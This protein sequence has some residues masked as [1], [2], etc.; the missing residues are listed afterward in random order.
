MSNGKKSK[1]ASARMAV[2]YLPILAMVLPVHNKLAEPP[3][4][5]A[6]V[7]V[8]E[9][10]KYGQPQF[11]VKENPATELQRA[12]QAFNFEKDEDT[13]VITLKSIIEVYRDEPDV[14][15]LS[16]VNPRISLE[17]QSGGKKIIKPLTIMQSPMINAVNILQHFHVQTEMAWD[18]I[19][20]LITSLREPTNLASFTITVESELWWDELIPP[21]T[22]TILILTSTI[23]RFDTEAVMMMKPAVEV[24]GGGM[25]R[26]KKKNANVGQIPLP[27]PPAPDPAPPTTPQF[28]AP[29]KIDLK[30]IITNVYTKEDILIF[31]PLLDDFSIKDQRWQIKTIPK[32]NGESYT[33]CYQPTNVVDLFNFLPQ[34]FRIKAKDV[35]AEPRIAIS[36]NAGASEK[37]EDYKINIAITMVPYYHPFAKKDLYT[38]LDKITKGV[39]KFC[40]LGLNGYKSAK[41]ALRSAY[42]GANAIFTG[43][44]PD[45]IEEIDALNGFVLS[46]ECTLESFDYFRREIS[47]SDGIIIGDI[48]FELVSGPAGSQETTEQRI[49]V[50]LN[51]NKLGGISINMEPD[52]VKGEGTI[53]IKGLTISNQYPCAM[54][55]KG[56]DVTLLS[57]IEE[58]VYEA[59]YNPVLDGTWPAT[60]QK[61]ESKVMSL[62][63][64]KTDEET[65]WTHLVCEPYGVAVE[66][67][68]QEVLDRIIDYATGDPQIWKLEVSCP[69]FEH[70]KEQDDPTLA[71]FRQVSNLIVDVRNEKGETFSV[72]LEQKTPVAT[73]EM[74]RSI[75]EILRSQ[76]ITDRK[77][78]YRVGTNY[79]INPAHWTDWTQ[80]ESTASDYLL[81][82]PQPLTAS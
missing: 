58:T 82:R 69:L 59:D 49:P 61:N 25:V 23:P 8:Y 68:P 46:V 15:P 78:Q 18:D 16:I 44:M 52:V 80:P 70:W 51:I 81:V 50:E 77:Y 72:K 24:G 35:S 67:N 43:K 47:E 7:Y 6:K 28:K 13:G 40:Q 45:F 63:A 20:G 1:V 12:S 11:R 19:K 34:A 66:T 32:T 27:P 33:L 41:F 71:P 22:P 64:A 74:S 17:F 54:S 4:D 48:V 14:T 37:P 56:M 55:I 79:L 60:I 53:E 39:T 38:D 42:S 65:L 76:R 31:G 30:N 75:N 73:I 36:M 21:P 26:H 3:G 57:Q 5:P 10:R 62:T 9:G 2:D 29:Q